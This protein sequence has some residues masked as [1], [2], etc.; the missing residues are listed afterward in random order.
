VISRAE[1]QRRYDEIAQHHLA[2]YRQHGVN[3]WMSQ[4]PQLRA[5]TVRKAYEWITAPARVLDAG[6]GIGLMLA[7]LAAGFDA[8][9]IDIS[10]DYI[11][12][13]HEQG[14]NATIGWLDALPFPDG[15][16][17]AAVCCDVFEHVQQPDDILAELKRVVKPGGVLVVRVP[18]GDHTGVGKD[19]GFG[20]PVH[21]QQWDEPELR[22]FLGGTVL[23]DD[24]WE[25]ELVMGVRL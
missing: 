10:A 22:A 11:E 6:C 14:L 20:Y 12:F 13:C 4:E 21:L 19:S 17:D 8:V 3:P 9:G 5:W 16:F 1:Y 25:H 18:D 15:S 23:G 24:E 2:H 7:D